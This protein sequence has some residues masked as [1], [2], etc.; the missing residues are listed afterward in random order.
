MVYLASHIEELAK[1]GMAFIATHK[2]GIVYL[3][4]EGI[5]DLEISLMVAPSKKVDD[6][7]IDGNF[8]HEDLSIEIGLVYNPG[9]EKD[10]HWMTWAL[11]E[12]IAHEICHY[13][14]YL[15]GRLPRNRKKELPA[16]K[17]YLQNHE[18][19]AQIAGWERVSQMT[20]DTV[21]KS[22]EIWFGRNYHFHGMEELEWK[23]VIQKIFFLRDKLVL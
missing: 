5:D 10:L 13:H 21:E 9:K 16:S 1:E 14:Q 12:I 23:K 2:K 19:E 8:C 22:A 20:G 3:E 11:N 17:Y 6:F 7:L 18:V 4:C 15:G